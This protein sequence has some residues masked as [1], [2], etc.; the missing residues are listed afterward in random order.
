[1]LLLLFI[2]APQQQVGGTSP[3][4]V[5]PRWR[6]IKPEWIRWFLEDDEDDVLILLS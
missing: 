6:T 4:K 3:R 1:M 2:G 5:G